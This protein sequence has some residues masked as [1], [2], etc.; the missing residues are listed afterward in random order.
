M[1]LISVTRIQENSEGS[2][3]RAIYRALNQIGFSF[4][5]ETKRVVI[6]PNLCYYWD[7][8]TGQTTDPRFVAALVNLIQEMVSPDID[9]SIVES[10]ASAMRC[11]HAFQI[12]GYDKLIE[13]YAV[14]LVNLTEDKGVPTSVSVAGRTFNFVIPK[15]IQE[16]HLKINVPKIKYTFEKIKITCALKNIFGCN[17]YRRKFRYHPIIEEA[18]VALNKAFQFD[19]C[20]I[21]A[22]IVSGIRPRRL[23]M[24][25]AG[26]DPVAIDAAATHVAG[27]NPK[28]INY[29]R[30]AER[31]G[32]GNTHYI[33]RGV[34][35]ET[36][37]AMYPKKGAQSKVLGKAYRLINCL[38]LANRL[39]LQ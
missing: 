35:L 14:R 9:I 17:P 4:P 20:L 1:S 10:D 2:M 22:N 33:P 30:L 6:K 39:G 36:L 24:V 34:P 25:V 5:K 13:E 21:D 11:K 26:R 7:S 16:A 23:G 3:E 19:L 37:R 15:T 8:S 12:L 32:L 38:G 29:I 31:E 28:S 18:I 27:E